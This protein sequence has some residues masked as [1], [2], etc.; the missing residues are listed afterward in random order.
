MV[1]RSREE[2]I[3]RILKSISEKREKK[4]SHIIFECRLSFEQTK[5]YLPFMEKLGM[6]K[7]EG[8]GWNITEQGR[9]S[10]NLLDKLF[11]RMAK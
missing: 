1:Y 8:K 11:V 5:T 6:I 7:K 3:F 2:I 9:S 10:M 4:I